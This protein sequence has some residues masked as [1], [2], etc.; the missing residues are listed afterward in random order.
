MIIWN[1]GLTKSPSTR[2]IRI[3]R[4]N[5]GSQ[6][7]YYPK[8]KQFFRKRKERRS[9]Y[10]LLWFLSYDFWFL[11]DTAFDNRALTV[12]FFIL[13][14][15][16]PLSPFCFVLFFFSFFIFG[17]F[18]WSNFHKVRH[19]HQPIAFSPWHGDQQS[20]SQKFGKLMKIR[21]RLQKFNQTNCLLYNLEVHHEQA[22]HQHLKLCNH[23]PSLLDWVPLSR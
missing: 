5:T 3:R 4:S 16:L 19:S 18:I 8:K 6:K 13:N 7:V 10:F 2:H 1:S 21:I 17:Q 20:G 12:R 14:S 22:T 11:S 15:K 9:L 23:E